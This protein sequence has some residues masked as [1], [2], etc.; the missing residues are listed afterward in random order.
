MSGRHMPNASSIQRQTTTTKNGCAHGSSFP[1]CYWTRS[2]N[3]TGTGFAR[4]SEYSIPGQYRA[5]RDSAA[6]WHPLPPHQT[7]PR[8]P[9]GSHVSLRSTTHHGKHHKSYVA[10]WGPH[11][12]LHGNASEVTDTT[13]PSSTLIHGCGKHARPMTQTPYNGSLVPSSN[14]QAPQ[15]HLGRDPDLSTLSTHTGRPSSLVWRTSPQA[16]TRNGTVILVR[17]PVCTHHEAPEG[18]KVAIR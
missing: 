13:S 17:L 5:Y 9:Y 4:W 2:P 11:V 15:C 7:C 14:K 8:H 1:Y 16:S 3:T 6:S 18:P 10:W 12:A